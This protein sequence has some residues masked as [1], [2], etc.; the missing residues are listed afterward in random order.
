[1]RSDWARISD[2]KYVSSHLIRALTKQIYVYILLIMDEELVQSVKSKCEQVS[3]S[4]ANAGIRQA[5]RAITQLY[6]QILAPCDLQVTQFTLLVSCAVTGS[7]AITTLADALVMDRT[8]LARNLKPLE[9]KGMIKVT[10][11]K[12]RRVRI[13]TLLEKGYTAL[14]M[15]LPLWQQ[16]QTKVEE[17]FGK[18]QLKGLLQDLS[19]M[20]KVARL[21]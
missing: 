17:N 4:C 9:T 21:K 19:A 13:V 18:V 20:V 2:D 3:K 10:A 1:M 16:A 12:D 7:V 5:A 6:D 15:A 14:T 8:T 11:G